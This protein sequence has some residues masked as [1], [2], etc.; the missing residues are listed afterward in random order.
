MFEGS[1]HEIQEEEM[2]ERLAVYGSLQEIK[3][4]L[5]RLRS[6]LNQISCKE[7]NKEY[8]PRK[9]DPATFWENMRAGRYEKL[10]GA[11][12]KQSKLLNKK[13]ERS[14]FDVKEI[15]KRFVAS[16]GWKD[17]WLW[18][19][20]LMRPYFKAKIPPRSLPQKILPLNEKK[21]I[22]MVEEKTWRS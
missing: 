13:T 5:P 21:K 2:L 6:E 20:S 8:I 18:R 4:T 7:I 10:Y 14:G 1:K 3:K 12:L 17:Q 19:S 11:G 22:G 16:L 15:K 9:S